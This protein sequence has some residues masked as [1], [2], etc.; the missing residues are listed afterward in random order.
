MK[1][2]LI[3]G[4]SGSGKSIALK[5]LEDENFFCIDNLPA[6]CLHKVVI[7]LS[8]EPHEAIAVSIDIRS[9]ESVTEVKRVV[10][11]L[12]R[13]GHTMNV[14]FLNARTEILLQRYAESRR[15]H[16]LSLGLRNTN[17]LT[18]EEFIRIEKEHMS[19]L[20]EISILIDTSELHPNIL[21]KWIIDLAQSKPKGLTLLFESFAFKHGVPLDANFVFDVRCLPSPHYKQ[22]LKNLSGLDKAVADYLQ[23]APSVRQMIHD[24]SQF[25]HTWIPNVLENRSSLTIAIG[26]SGGQHRSVHCVEM[27]AQIF[28]GTWPVL[29]RHRALANREALQAKSARWRNNK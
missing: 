14:F 12:T 25:L 11:E 2:V 18:L 6:S 13:I 7:D 10:G 5:A 4:I 24:M 23:E 3:T 27:L 1:I 19:V 9:G 16:P 20:D 26:C 8:E 29:V 28:R 22:S 17:H 15:P 21:R